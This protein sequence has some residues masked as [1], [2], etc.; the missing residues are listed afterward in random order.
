[1]PMK[2]GESDSAKKTS[3]WTTDEVGCRDRISKAAA[4]VGRVIVPL[5]LTL[6]QKLPKKLSKAA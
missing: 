6:P 4:G 5:C 3:E 2:M 1:M